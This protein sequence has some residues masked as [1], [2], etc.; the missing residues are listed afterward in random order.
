MRI[1]YIGTRPREIAGRRVLVVKPGEVFEVGEA[2]GASL[3]QQE[4]KFEAVAD[5][6]KPS[7]RKAPEQVASESKEKEA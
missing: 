4:R 3:L 1:K 7:S 2:L 6:P 5:P